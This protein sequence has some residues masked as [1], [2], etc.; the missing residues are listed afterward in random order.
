MRVRVQS[1]LIHE[2]KQG[3]GVRAFVVSSRTG[4]LGQAAVHHRQVEL[5]VES[6]DVQAGETLDFVADIGNKLS[7]NQFLWKAVITSTDEPAIT[8]DSQRDFSSR[9]VQQLGPWE[10]L[11]QVLLAANEFVFVD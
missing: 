10:Q 8:F 1:T 4:L 7:Y 6:L 11:A 5:N 3:E 9:S 2:P